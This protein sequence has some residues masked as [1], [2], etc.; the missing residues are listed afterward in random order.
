MS[1]DEQCSGDGPQTPSAL[2]VHL[3]WPQS[4]SLCWW[5]RS[6]HMGQDSI[7]STLGSSAPSLVVL[8]ITLPYRPLLQLVV[9][10]SFPSPQFR[11]TT[12]HCILKVKHDSCLIYPPL[13]P[14]SSGSHKHP[15]EKSIFSVAKRNSRSA[16]GWSEAGFG[17]GWSCWETFVRTGTAPR[18]RG[19]SPSTKQRPQ[20]TLNIF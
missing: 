15:K 17:S 3:R 11:D 12:Q 1:Q 10:W 13:F 20:S 14:P 5:D 2:N 18:N 6:H 9:F 8:S 19:N 16:W 7:P 4:P